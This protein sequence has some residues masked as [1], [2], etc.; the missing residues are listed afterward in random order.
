ML[1]SNMLKN[2]AIKPLFSNQNSVTTVNN[3]SQAPISATTT[4]GNSRSSAWTATAAYAQTV[5]YLELIRTIISFVNK[6]PSRKSLNESNS[7]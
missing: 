5:L 6:R 3:S 7:S 1:S 2:R 4:A